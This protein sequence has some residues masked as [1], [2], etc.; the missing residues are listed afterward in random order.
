MVGG[1]QPRGSSV[2]AWLKDACAEPRKYWSLKANAIRTII[3]LWTP[4]QAL[5]QQ[6]Q[7]SRKLLLSFGVW[8]ADIWESPQIV[9]PALLDLKFL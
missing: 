1:W 7:E 3:P 9:V 8:T 5:F 6:E 2:S 4:M